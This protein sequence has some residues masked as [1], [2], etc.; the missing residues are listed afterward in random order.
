MTG[1]RLTI[2]TPE[3]A[4]GELFETPLRCGSNNTQLLSDLRGSLSSVASCRPPV[5]RQ[6]RHQVS[7]MSTLVSFGGPR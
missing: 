5:G 7:A 4:P 6:V 3:T 2:T 1:P